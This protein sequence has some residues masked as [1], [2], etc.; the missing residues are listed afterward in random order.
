MASQGGGGD[1]RAAQAVTKWVL[2]LGFWVQGFRCFPW[3]VV[4]FY[5]K[6]GLGV[7]PSTLQLLQHSTNLPMVGKPL[8]GLVSDAVYLRG[9]HRLPY[10]ALG[11][12]LQA[13]SWFC[14]ALMPPT[15][16]SVPTLT[17]LLL[18]SNLGAA[19]AE[20]A[21]DAIVAEAGRQAH[22]GSAPSGHLQSFAWMFGASAGALGNLLGGVAVNQLPPSSIFFIFGVLAAAQFLVTAAIPER[23]LNLPQKKGGV[24]NKS[25]G[26][27]R[28][29]SELSMALRKPEIFFSIAWFALSYAVVPILMGTMFY[30]QTQH[31]NLDPSVLGLSKVFGQLA[32]LAWSIAYN[33]RFKRVPTRKLLAALQGTIALFMLSDALFVDGFY[34]RIG[35]P[36]AA[37]VVF[38]SGLQEVLFLFKVLPFSVLMAQLCPAGCEGSLM[39][40]LMS[41]LALATIVSGYL[42]VALAAYIGVSGNDFSGLRKAV[43]VEAACTL[44]PLWLVSWIPGDRRPEKKQQGDETIKHHRGVRSLISTLVAAVRPSSVKLLLSDFLQQMNSR[45]SIDWS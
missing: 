2:G 19:I 16:V 6:D 22:Q 15:I 18:L 9:Q 20:V 29:I 1:G 27:R 24:S 25:S 21:N 37:Y 17:L 26:I 28:Q 23:A 5:L 34:R 10:I 43:L 38:F 13:L 42:G 41:A 36:D 11:A 30:Y 33:R 44:A 45:H 3:T 4:N 35:L 8:Y 12:L 31:L 14:I 39:A 32:V 40:F 7:S